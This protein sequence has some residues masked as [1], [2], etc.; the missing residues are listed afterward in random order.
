MS[1][2]K[3]TEQELKRIKNMFP[4][5]EIEAIKAVNE[6]DRKH[7]SIFIKGF[8]SELHTYIPIK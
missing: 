8:A 2:I 6:G 4:D 1:E 3:L 7:V 5:Q